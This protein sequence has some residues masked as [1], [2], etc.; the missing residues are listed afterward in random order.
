MVFVYPV[1]FYDFAAGGPAPKV[2]GG[3]LYRMHRFIG[4]MKRHLSEIAAKIEPVFVE[5]VFADTMIM[6]PVTSVFAPKASI[7]CC[8][9]IVAYHAFHNA[10][11]MLAFETSCIVYH[12]SLLFIFVRRSR[13]EYGPCYCE[14]L[15]R[16]TALS[17]CIP[18]DDIN[19]PRFTPVSSE[20]LITTG[21]G[22]LTAITLVPRARR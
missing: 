16:H 10:Q 15:V 9:E 5:P 11:Y 20:T 14:M 12:E 18:P 8:S 21:S 1:N 7:I 2:P 6:K 17:V 22:L 19:A 4:Y 3:V 13:V